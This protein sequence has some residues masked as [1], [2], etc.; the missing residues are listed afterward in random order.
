[1]RRREKALQG[2]RKK[3]KKRGNTE[4]VQQLWRDTDARVPLKLQEITLDW[5]NTRSKGRESSLELPEL[6]FPLPC[7]RPDHLC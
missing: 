4:T 3:K 5:C 7:P 6:I 2:K 1:M